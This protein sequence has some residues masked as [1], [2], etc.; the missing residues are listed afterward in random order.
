MV[1]DEYRFPGSHNAAHIVTKAAQHG[2][3]KASVAGIPAT[4]G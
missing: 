3:D 2:I 1:S 4:G